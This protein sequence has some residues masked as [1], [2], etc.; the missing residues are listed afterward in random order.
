MRRVA[1]TP[2]QV[3]EYQ[4]PEAMGKSSDSRKGS[5]VARFGK[6]VQLSFDA[7][8]PDVLRTLFDAA[9][10]DHWDVS[11]FE[12][13]R[14]READERAALDDFARRWQP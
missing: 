7:L 1:L 2:Q 3:A 12:A 11:T 6:L 4:L 14:T 5:F 8:P 9:I 13:V 10:T